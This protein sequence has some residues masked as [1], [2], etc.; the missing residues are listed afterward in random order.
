MTDF[1]DKIPKDEPSFYKVRPMNYAIVGGSSGK[2]IGFAHSKVGGLCM[3][4]NYKYT[5]GSRLVEVNTG[6]TIGIVDL[7]GSI[8]EEDF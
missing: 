8:K 2:V 7:D 6:K 5:P 1:P 4:G 3:L